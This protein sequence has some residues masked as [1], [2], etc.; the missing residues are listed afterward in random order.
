[1]PASS[2]DVVVGDD[3]TE[4]W[5]PN[6]PIVGVTM[7]NY[8][9]ATGGAVND[10]TGMYFYLTCGDTNAGTFTMTFA[11]NWNIGGP[12]YPA[13]TWAGNIPWIADPYDTKNGCA[14]AASLYV[15]ADVGPCPTEGATI[16]LGPGYDPLNNIGGIAD[17]CDCAGPWA[18]MMDPTPKTIRYV[19]KIADRD[20]APPGDTINY[21][22]YYGKP[23]TAALTS[24]TIF[25][26]MPSY[27]HLAGLGTPAPDTGW[28]PEPGPPMTLKWTIPSPGATAGGATNAVN[29]SAT[30]DWGNGEVFEPG[31]GDVAAPE[32]AF[33][34]NQAHMSWE[35]GTGAGSCA[36][37]RSS[38]KATTVVRRY[39]FWLIGDND[40]LYSQTYGQPADEMIYSIYVKNLSQTKTWWNIQIWDTVPDQ[41]DTWCFDCGMEDPCTG[42]TM[43]P[44][45]CAAASAGKYITAGSKTVLTWKLDMP[46]GMTLNMRWKAQ[47]RTTAASGQTAISQASIHSF[48]RTGVVDGT[49]N[50]V[51]TRRFTHLATIILPTTYVSYVGFAGSSPTGKGC[52]GFYLPFFPLNKKAQF[53][54][55]GIEYQG[56]GWSTVGGVSQSIGCL[57]GDCLG[58]F[59]G[60]GGCTL[61]SGLIPGGG[62]GGC[63]AERAPARYDPVAWQTVCP[64]HPFEFIYKITSNAPVLWQM[65]TYMT[66]MGDDYHTY[67]PATTMTY[68]GM[69]HYMWRAEDN[70]FSLTPN[71]GHSLSL[72]NT[73][74]DPYGNYNPALT[75]TVHLF[76]WDNL[77]LSWEYRDTREIDGESQAYVMGTTPA[78]AGPW[79]TVSSD[80]QIIINQGMNTNSMLGCCCGACANDFSHMMPTRENGTL[81]SGVGV[82]TFYG[83]AQGFNINGFPK[84][85][86]GNCGAANATYEIWTYIPGGALPLP[87]EP[88]MLAGNSGSW[89]KL[90]TESVPAGI[91]T[92]GNPQVYSPDGPYFDNSSLALY[93]I[94]VTAGGPIQVQSGAWTQR[95]C[96]GGSMLHSIAGGQTGTDFWFHQAPSEP[97]SGGCLCNANG[98]GPGYTPTQTLSFFCP[99]QGMNVK[100]Q[101][102]GGA[103]GGLVASYTTTGPD[104]CVSFTNITLLDAGSANRRNWHITSAAG[105]SMI[106]QY[107]QCNDSQ[108]GYTAPFLVSGTHYNIIV[109]PVVYSGQSFWITVVVV[110]ATSSTML[111][112]CGTTSFTS[113]DPAAKIESAGMDG[114]NY[115]WD[116]NE[117]TA[118]CKGAGCVGSCD[119]GI[120]MFFNVTFTKLGLNAI[121]GIDIFDGSITGLG[122]FMVV[123]T[124]VKLFKEPRLVIAASGDT[125]QFKICWSAYSSASAFTFVIT[126]AVP[127]GTTYVPEVASAMM[128][129]STSGVAAMV[130]Y[131]PTASASPPATFTSVPSAAPP[132]GLSWLRWTVPVVGV[133]TTGCACFRVSVN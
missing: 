100:A 84:V 123:G 3:I 19:M 118:T 65:L 53:E 13:W 22:I 48:G 8:G 34:Y 15:Y 37:G 133:K 60:S 105:N 25:D 7:V 117:V 73:G 43:T 10:I 102:G 28:N 4:S 124:D 115:V 58:G 16:R 126:D 23:G 14:G 44:S 52:F 86:V 5:C 109:P 116:S 29:F 6:G 112:Y 98:N 96:S 66:Q 121:V 27:T 39:L 80:T 101:T 90:S 1:V 42:W 24:I 78:E 110:D 87:I 82:G 46:A 30:V 50:Q 54:L 12:V 72:I 88:P 47:V 89:V 55:R 91:A 63:K 131:S 113:T 49:G 62:F 70:S 85:V 75:T 79:R 114:Y 26:T 64:T 127:R 130:A 9:T 132:A 97:S 69:M 40:V 51:T 18:T 129:G 94:R 61:G 92:A 67:A 20:S 68:L 31:S 93:K 41:V 21:T 76:R 81:V 38:N 35:P 95:S 74:A 125:V 83:L 111:D 56:A 11:G 71:Y 32:G 59:P 119:N 122:S 45:G 128:C 103:L 33:L 106:G 120:K 104:Q 2:I 108:K 99:K 107:I 17:D 36:P 77:N 57:I